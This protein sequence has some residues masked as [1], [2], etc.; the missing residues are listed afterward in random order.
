MN[1]KRTS[2]VRTLLTVLAAAVALTSTASGGPAAVGEETSSSPAAMSGPPVGPAAAASEPPAD[3][4]SEP[5]PAATADAS[6]LDPHAVEAVAR[7]HGISVAQA[8]TRLSREQELAERGARLE[9]E[10]RG[11][12]GGSYL[13][14]AGELVVTTLDEAGDAAVRR[15]GAKH[16]RVDDTSARLEAVMRQLDRQAERTGAGGVQ[17]W[18]VDVP[19]NAVVV[20]VTEGADDQATRAMLDLVSRLGSSARIEHAPASETPRTTAWLVGGFQFVPPTGGTCSVGF[21]T[22]DS[23]NR[24]V[25]LTAGHCVT[26]TGWNSRN[27][28]YIGQTRTANYPGDDF[29]TFWNSYPS[30]WQP[31]VS[32]SKYNGTYVNVRGIWNTPAVGATV[33]KSGRTTGYTCGKITALNQTVLYDGKFTLYGLVRHNACVEP[34]D[35]GGSNISAGAYALG[36]TSGAATVSKTD[37]RC[38]SKIGKQN[39][40]WYQ[41]IGE[42]LSRNGL[43]LLYQR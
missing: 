42:A 6:S 36:V 32:V 41:P 39:V 38:L 7:E 12:S 9:R 13:D 25:V 31:S 22:V 40:S 2:S 21:N 20:T 14:R 28:Y 43:R 33:C 34:G 11:R 18:Y 17:G 4:G 8:R 16:Q 27:G 23:A 3:P 1:T 35:S 30:Y 15:G 10:L 26:S 37:T 29:G 5:D 19:S 24:N